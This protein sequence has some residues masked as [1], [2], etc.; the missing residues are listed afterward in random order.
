LA[1]GCPFF[2]KFV[3]PNGSRFSQSICSQYAMMNR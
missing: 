3:N 1:L 2:D